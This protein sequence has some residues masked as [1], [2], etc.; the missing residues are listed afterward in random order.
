MDWV[1]HAHAGSLEWSALDVEASR[2]SCQDRASSSASQTF[3]TSETD[4]HRQGHSPDA[5]RAER[6]GTARGLAE[7]SAVLGTVLQRLDAHQ[8]PVGS[9]ARQGSRRTEE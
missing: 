1:T 8:E 2:F 4:A 9:A 7:R 3:L 5:I 6:R